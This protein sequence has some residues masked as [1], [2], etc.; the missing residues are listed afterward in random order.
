MADGLTT[1]TIDVG[2]T[3]IAA[4]IDSVKLHSAATTD[5]TT[6]LAASGAESVTCSSTGGVIT[7]PSTDFTGG[8]ASAA[9]AGASVWRGATFAG[10]FGIDSGD[11]T[12]NAAGEYT[13]TSL[14]LT[15]SST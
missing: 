14:T 1:A 12:F 4:A 9:V 2:T 10:Y 13:L 5:G 8:G 3:A 15:G 6:N 11:V 7:V